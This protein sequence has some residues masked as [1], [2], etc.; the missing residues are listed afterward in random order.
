[1]PF[2]RDPLALYEDLLI[3]DH[4]TSSRTHD[5]IAKHF[6]ASSVTPEMLQ[7]IPEKKV[8]I[9]GAG[10]GGL[11]IAMMLSS[12][13]VDYEILEASTHTGGR[14]F[15]YAFK[16]DEAGEN[17]Y[18]DAG[19]MRFPL[20]KIKDG[21]YGEGF[22]K[23]LAK[24]TQFLGMERQEDNPEG[25]ILP[26]C[27]ET[28]F[29]YYNG[30]HEPP[31]DA[32]GMG[33]DEEYIQTGASAISAD[34]KEPFVSALK[35]DAVS[36]TGRKWGWEAIR[37][38]DALSVR[39][40]LATKYIPSARL[41][42]PPRHL[43][44]N[45]INWMG[46]TDGS[47]SGGYDRSFTEAILSSIAFNK[48]SVDWKCFKGGSQ[49]LTKKMEKWLKDKNNEV[50]FNQ[51]V[52]AVSETN[53]GNTLV[54]ELP[55]NFPGIPT[56]AKL[57]PANATPDLVINDNSTPTRKKY[58]LPCITVTTKKW[59][60]NGGE[61][62]QEHKYL[63]VF[64]T[65]PLPA[66]R[67]INLEAAKLNT[68][69]KN[70]LRQSDY[71]PAVKIAI[72]FSKAWWADLGIHGGQANTDL[73]IRTI[74]YPSY[75]TKEKPCNVL[76]A[77]YSWTTDA[78]RIAALNQN[79]ACLKDLVLANLA[80][81]HKHKDNKVTHEYL[82]SLFKD[83]HV[84]DWSRDEFAM[85]AFPYFC[86]GDFE[87]GFTSLVYPAASKRFHFASEAVSIRHAWVAGALNSAWR[88]VNT[89]LTVTGQRDKRVDFL[90]RWGQNADWREPISVNVDSDKVVIGDASKSQLEDGVP[91]SGYSVSATKGKV[92]TGKVKS[93][94]SD[95]LVDQFILFVDELLDEL[96]TLDDN[97]TG[98]CTDSKQGE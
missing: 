73:P 38:F 46:L 84:Q 20:P 91:A 32:S 96:K 57:A 41:Q 70:A 21:V 31:F 24:L 3:E 8:G 82:S 79:R 53:T 30:T 7:F 40:Y 5:F 64:S 89:Y 97:R 35:Q 13:G 28:W 69:Q 37:S 9:I 74:V 60:K 25:E 62:S 1:M 54:V 86:P 2:N 92:E 68:L 58:E 56:E 88:T 42:I 12:I 10:I 14:L 44:T 11:Y 94:A 29:S 67:N 4:R 39:G 48:E 93:A 33:V 75:G 27:H 18:Y 26:Y 87:E 45:V 6:K 81:A 83:M 78:E 71:G 55:A 90:K 77:S 51:R 34:F 50:R 23:R 16:G 22:M 80:E 76:I 95:D 65:L 36:G 72:R 63:H 61:T 66:L 47:S 52:T 19:A 15:T 98:E 43:P 59:D 85:G 17:D 49:T